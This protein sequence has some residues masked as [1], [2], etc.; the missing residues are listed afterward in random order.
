[1]IEPVPVDVKFEVEMQTPTSRF[2][3]PHEVPSTVSTPALVVTLDP[4]TKMPQA[5]Y[6]PF[7]ALPVIVTFPEVVDEMLADEFR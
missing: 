5:W 1:M 4:S 2:P 6:V 3:V 7:A